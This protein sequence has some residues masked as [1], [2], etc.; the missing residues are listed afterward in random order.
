MRHN[1][2]LGVA[3]AA[4][5]LPAAASAQETTSQIRGVVTTGGT[6]VSG[7]TVDVIDVNS[8]TKSQSTTGVDGAF[9]FNGLRAG[10]PYTVSVTSTT[11]NKTVTDI[12][13]VVQQVFN[14]P[15]DLAAAAT[16]A[17]GGTEG[18]DIV[19][20]ASRVRGAGTRTDGPQTIL[21]QA[22]IAKV[23]S[24]NRD[25]RDVERRDPFATLDRGSSGDRGG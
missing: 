23:A 1:L 20:T 16:A 2:L 9:S 22:D 11:G 5:I 12:Y 17:E 10:G 6:P 14:L 19:V 7:A 15:I 3:V 18:A 8:G 24:V 21:T 13:T 25:I 4:L